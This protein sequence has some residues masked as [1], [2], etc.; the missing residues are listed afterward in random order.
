MTLAQNN[1]VI[2]LPIAPI[3][4]RTLNPR[5]IAQQ[6]LTNLEIQLGTAPI[7]QPKLNLPE[8]FHK[9]SWWRDML[10][11]DWDFHTIHTVPEIEQYISR[12][13]PRARLT[14]FHLQHEG[15]FQPKVEN[16]V[17]GLRWISSMFFFESRVGRGTGMLRL[18][19]DEAGVWKAYSLYTS[20]QELKGFE[21]PLGLRRPQGTIESM[22]VNSSK[23]NWLDRRQSQLEFRNEEPTAILVGAGTYFAIHCQSSVLTCRRTSWSQYGSSVAITRDL[24]SHS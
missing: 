4:I 18:T 14:A 10:A 9:D 17:K 23:E 7:S 16:P 20:L 12:N 11:L 15:R 19:Q 2:Q 6:W 24:V 5:D 1:Y 13:Q 8:L 21:E 22:P 3:T